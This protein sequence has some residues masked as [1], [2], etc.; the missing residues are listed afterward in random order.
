[1]ETMMLARP[2]NTERSSC[3]PLVGASRPVPGALLEQTGVPA[4]VVG[5]WVE[6]G[7]AV[8][9][10]DRLVGCAGAVPS[11]GG[12]LDELLD[13]PGPRSPVE[14]ADPDGDDLRLPGHRRGGRCQQRGARDRRD[15]RAAHRGSSDHVWLS[16]PRWTRLVTGSAPCSSGRAEQARGRSWVL[17]HLLEFEHRVTYRRLRTAGP[18]SSP[19]PRVGHPWQVDARRGGRG[20]G[21]PERPFVSERPYQ[22]PPTRM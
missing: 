15:D 20:E 1:M 4:R 19:P 18:C 6:A 22:R 12:A 9:H 8:G 7:L 5:P 21:G 17:D 13:L 16:P 10:R 2:L 14:V 11:A 3:P